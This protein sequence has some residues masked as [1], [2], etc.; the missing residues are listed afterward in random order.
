MAKI[1]KKLAAFA[2]LGMVAVSTAGC[3]LS[4]LEMP[5]WLEQATCDHVYDEEEVLKEATCEQDGK[6]EK[7]CSDCGA[8]KIVIIKATGEHVWDDGVI[9]DGVNTKTCTVCGEQ[10]VQCNHRSVVCD[11]WEP[12]FGTCNDCGVNLTDS[13]YKA[14][15]GN[16]ITLRN[17]TWYRYNLI[18]EFYD[19]PL[20]LSLNLVADLPGRG[21]EDFT[22]DV[23]PNLSD[24]WAVPILRV[25][26]YTILLG[27]SDEVPDMYVDTGVYENCLKQFR[28]GNWIYFYT[29]TSFEVLFSWKT[30]DDM[31]DGEAS[32]VSYSAL[33]SDGLFE[34]VG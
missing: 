2:L 1:F 29:S 20:T 14:V 10:E 17:N 32:V 3:G 28:V 16:S 4:E 7:I 15:V 21:T 25:D 8:T 30:V 9:A 27:L 6:V 13:Q 18:N 26:D 5:E 33:S 12:D 24:I 31:G 11:N 19:S 34:L 23:S 22:I